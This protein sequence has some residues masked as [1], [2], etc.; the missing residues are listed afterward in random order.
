M[1][2]RKRKAAPHEQ[3]DVEAA[4]AASRHAANRL[5]GCALLLPPAAVLPLPGQQAG[6]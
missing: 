1:S 6:R 5:Q 3:Q 4:V 2:S